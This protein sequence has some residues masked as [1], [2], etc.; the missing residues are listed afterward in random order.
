MTARGLIALLSTSMVLVVLA[1]CGSAGG[2][3]RA[4]E[5]AGATPGAAGGSPGDGMGPVDRGPVP[6][7]L[8]LVIKPGADPQAVAR[9]VVGA[10]ATA[11]PTGASGQAAGRT[12]LVAVPAGQETAALARAQTDPDVVSASFNLKVPR[13]AGA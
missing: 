6:S 13:P 1:A 10:P 5:P 12:Y 2:Q 4:A 11:Q 9:R 3:G 7:M 8:T